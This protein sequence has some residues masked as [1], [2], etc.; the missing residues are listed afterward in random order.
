MSGLR[1]SVF[2]SSVKRVR[3][4]FRRPWSSL[5]CIISQMVLISRLTS[6]DE[7][8]SGIVMP[9]ESRYGRGMSDKAA[10]S[11]NSS[12]FS[13]L[14]LPNAVH[15]SWKSCQ[16]AR[17]SASGELI[18]E[19]MILWFLIRRWYGF[20]GNASGES[21]SVSMSGSSSH[22]A[23]GAADF[24]YFKSWPRMLCPISHFAPPARCAI[25]SKAV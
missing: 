21:R 6:G 3:Q 17:Q 24:R 25:S 23:S 18:S 7:T 4:T 8:R 13:A 5:S 12:G 14:I 16:Q 1:M 15:W 2:I 11:A 19:E 20:C 22:A 10:H 9:S